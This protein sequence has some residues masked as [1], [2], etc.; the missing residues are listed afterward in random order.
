MESHPEPKSERRSRRR[1]WQVVLSA[2][3]VGLIALSVAA[4]E[5]YLAAVVV[6]SIV[7]MV[8]IFRFVFLKRPRLLYHSRQSGRRLCLLVLVLFAKQLPASRKIVAFAR[9]ALI[10]FGVTDW[11]ADQTLSARAHHSRR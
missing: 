5:S 1:P 2:G 7:A 10:G 4:T 11:Y 9:L 3:L 8:G 6:V